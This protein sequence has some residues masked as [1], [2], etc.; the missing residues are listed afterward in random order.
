MGFAWEKVKA[1]IISA[2]GPDTTSL[3]QSFAREI[4]KVPEKVEAITRLVTGEV[5]IPTA[6][7]IHQRVTLQSYPGHVAEVE[8]IYREVLGQHPRTEVRRDGSAR[9][10]PAHAGG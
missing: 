7:Q 3:L 9:A 1:S 8:A 5:A 10:T 4:A 6:R 2:L